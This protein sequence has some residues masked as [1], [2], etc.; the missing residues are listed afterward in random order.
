M[1]ISV[2]F[3]NTITQPRKDGVLKL[4]DN[5]KEVMDKLASL[6]VKFNLLTAR[7]KSD[8]IAE[9]IE[10]CY[11]WDLPI[12]IS[13]PNTKRNANYYLDDR[14]FGSGPVNWLEFYHFILH[15]LEIGEEDN[16]D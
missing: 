12:D 4:N 9:A 13:S 7:Q 2:D 5:C 10:M 14:N 15:Q 3:D 8:E 1:T 6:G 11:I 16:S